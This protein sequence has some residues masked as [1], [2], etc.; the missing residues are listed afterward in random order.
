MMKGNDATPPGASPAEAV[1]EAA[2]LDALLHAVLARVP[3][4]FDPEAHYARVER[5]IGGTTARP[6][7][8]LT[9]L[10]RL[11]SPL[12]SFAL[13]AACTLLGVILWQLLNYAP[14]E[15]EFIPLGAESETPHVLH[16]RFRDDATVTAVR[17][18]LQAVA[19]E[20]V[21][22]PD[23]KGFWRVKV[24]TPAAAEAARRLRNAPIV[25][26]VRPQP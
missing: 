22:G 7:H 16:V 13:G 26:D 12:P 9:A 2:R 19:A 23:A 14:R 17:T 4:G 25:L 5:L 24:A 11:W 8:W 15:V 3:E 6:R 20:V 21:G 18:S 1:A 10:Q